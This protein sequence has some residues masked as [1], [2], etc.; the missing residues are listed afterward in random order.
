MTTRNYSSI[1][2]IHSDLKKKKIIDEVREIND[3]TFKSHKMDEEEEVSIEDVPDV[4]EESAVLEF[5]LNLLQM[6]HWFKLL[7]VPSSYDHSYDQYKGWTVVFL[8]KGL[9]MH[10]Y[11]M[12]YKGV[13]KRCNLAGFIW[14]SVRFLDLTSDL[15]SLSMSRRCCRCVQSHRV[16]AY[17]GNSVFQ[18]WEE[19]I[20]LHDP[21]RRLDCSRVLQWV[22]F[23]SSRSKQRYRMR[24][25]LTA[26]HICLRHS[27]EKRQRGWSGRL[28]KRKRAYEV[29]KWSSDEIKKLRKKLERAKIDQRSCRKKNWGNASI[30]NWESIYKHSHWTGKMHQSVVLKSFVKL[31]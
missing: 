8:R 28:E 19:A 13:L 6:I 29:L 4:K 15:L 18:Q 9:Y 30:C 26:S 11:S 1:G 25:S 27:W 16:G 10:L 22:R 5:R 3:Q 24:G 31:W 17:I 23:L 20:K 12:F 21:K 2:S 14:T 7:V